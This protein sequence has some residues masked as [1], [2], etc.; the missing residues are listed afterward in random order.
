MSAAPVG[1][2]VSRDSSV[3]RTR[4]PLRIS[5]VAGPG[6]GS[7]PCAASTTPVPMGRGP[8]L[9]E[10]ASRRSSAAQL[11][12]TSTI[13]STAPT[14]WKVTSSG[15]LPWTAPSATARRRKAFSAR[16]EARSERSAPSI[17]VRMS[18]KVLW[19][20]SSGYLTFA[21]SAATLLTSTCSVARSKGTPMPRRDFVISG[22]GAPAATR[23]ASAMSPAA[24]PTG[25]KWTWVT[26]G[27]RWAEV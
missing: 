9:T 1:V 21:R 15:S 26:A 22:S 23:A 4:E 17:R 18:L 27:P 16:K 20:C 19:S 5:S 10:S 25:W 12:T 14:S 8:Q 3:Q 7:G 6:T 24:P 13:E 11:P 2:V